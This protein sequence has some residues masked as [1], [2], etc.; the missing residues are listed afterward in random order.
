MNKPEERLTINE[1]LEDPWFK[2]INDLKKENK[3]KYKELKEELKSIFSGLQGEIKEDN[4]QIEIKPKIDEGDDKPIKKSF[5]ENEDLYF[6]LNMQ[7]K[8]FHKD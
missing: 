8:K 6:P 2:E 3:E 7:P 4:E 5:S 1:I